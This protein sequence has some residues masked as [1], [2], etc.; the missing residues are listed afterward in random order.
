VPLIAAASARYPMGGWDKSP[1]GRY[2]PWALADI[3]RVSLAYGN[4]HRQTPGTEDDLLSCLFAYSSLDDPDLTVDSSGEDLFRFFSRLTSE[5]MPFQRRMFNGLGRTIAMFE[6]TPLAQPLELIGPGWDEDLLG[7]SL[8]HYVRAAL[9]LQTGAWKNSGTFDLRWL[10]Q[11]QFAE[12]IE[13]LPKSTILSVLRKQFMTDVAAFKALQSKIPSPE[14]EFRRFGYNPLWARPVV[15]GIG[16]TLLVPVIEL[17]TL[18]ASPL[19]IYYSGISHHG[20]AFARDVGQLTEAYVGRQLRLLPPP[21][22]VH[23]A[24]T[25]G[26]DMR[27]SVDWIVVTPD[28]TVLIEVKSVRPTEPVRLGTVAASAEMQRMLGKAHTQ[29]ARTAALVRDRHPDFSGIPDQ[30]MI[31]LIV[32]LEPFDTANDPF[33]ALQFPDATIPTTVC[34]VEDI[35]HLVVTDPEPVRLLIQNL[36]STGVINVGAVLR[37]RP[38]GY[39][40]VLVDAFDR[41]Q[42]LKR[43][44]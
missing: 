44:P 43:S 13:V 22:V 7:A 36:E 17:L 39:N 34:S 30:P 18:K 31:G 42:W 9:F 4:E 14:A 38:I 27:E 35:E 21:H 29:I 26:R 37:E 33:K 25:Y 3:A 32:T 40:Q 5:Q 23:P 28:V 15:E 6:Q 24:I 41:Y 20:L 16:A 1:G 10:D 11:P 19:G 12:V 2:T 8:E